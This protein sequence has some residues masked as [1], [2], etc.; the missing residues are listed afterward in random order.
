MKVY[1]N[2]DQ[3]N[4]SQCST[5]SS[6]SSSSSSEVSTPPTTP[7]SHATQLH[8]LLIFFLSEIVS[9]IFLIVFIFFVAII[10]VAIHIVVAFTIVYRKLHHQ[11]TT[12]TDN[13][14]SFSGLEEEESGGVGLSLSDLQN[15][16]SFEY[17]MVVEPT[18]HCIVCLERFVKGE[19]CRSLPRCNHVFHTSCV[20]SWLIQVPSCPLCRQIVVKPV[21][22]QSLAD[23]PG[24]SA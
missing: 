7:Q 9:T 6:S 20:D 18:Q 14:M 13:T 2:V 1:L 5:S 8:D 10:K 23:S 4:Y 19:S 16:S 17:E 15:L 12:R 11:R 24:S 21:V 22:N 3:R